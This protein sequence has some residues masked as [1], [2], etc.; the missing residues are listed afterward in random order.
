M[1]YDDHIHLFRTW[2]YQVSEKKQLRW[3][4]EPRDGF[5]QGP[6]DLGFLRGKHMLLELAPSQVALLIRGGELRA[7]FLE[8]AHHLAIGHGEGRIPPDGRLV[9]LAADRPLELRWDRERALRPAGRDGSPAAVVRGRCACRLKAPSQFF[10]AFLRHSE[11]A[12]TETILRVVETL[13]LARLEAVLAGAEDV[14][15]AQALRD[16]TAETLGL[17]LRPYGLDCES[18]E[19]EVR[20]GAAAAGA[21]I[22]GQPVPEHVNRG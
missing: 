6:L 7:V 14:T 19:L 18:L 9:F 21:L 8:G 16:L 13:V 2:E 17:E 4:I 22:P 3:S 15:A 12:G 20:D 1:S 5:V 11:D 10:D